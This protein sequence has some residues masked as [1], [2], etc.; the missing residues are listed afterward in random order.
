ML[1]VAVAVRGSGSK[2]MTI[3][4]SAGDD[5]YVDRPGSM[6][7]R[8]GGDGRELHRHVRPLIWLT[9]FQGSRQAGDDL[10]EGR[11][12][13]SVA[14]DELDAYGQMR[15]HNRTDPNW[16]QQSARAGE[17]DECLG[18]K[19]DPDIGDYGGVSPWSQFID[20]FLCVRMWLVAYHGL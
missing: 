8:A 11:E 7:G 6:L 17:V 19:T 5:R 12:L 4:L 9:P 16:Q 15:S 18:C 1:Q 3:C 10:P 13:G 14:D 20:E 2:C